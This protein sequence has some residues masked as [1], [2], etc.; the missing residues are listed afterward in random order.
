MPTLPRAENS[1]SFI[2]LD[3]LVGELDESLT[4]SAALNAATA[5]EAGVPVVA[6]VPSGKQQ[7]GRAHV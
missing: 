6:L 5:V 7:I 3:D 4:S 1:A 2:T